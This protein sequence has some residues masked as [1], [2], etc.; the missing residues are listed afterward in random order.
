VTV[1]DTG[2]G[3]PEDDLQRAFERFYLYDKAIRDGRTV[4][5]GL[6]L[7]I[8]KQLTNAMGGTVDVRSEIGRG[9]TFVVRLPSG[10]TPARTPSPAAAR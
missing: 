3:L 8:V 5:S 1:A 9:T 10:R 7:A 6:G 2:S 4:G